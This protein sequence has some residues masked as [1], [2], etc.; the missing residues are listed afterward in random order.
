MKTKVINNKYIYYQSSPQCFPSGT[1]LLGWPNDANLLAGG[2]VQV[3]MS[4]VAAWLSTAT[5]GAPTGRFGHTSIWTGSEMIIWGGEAQVGFDPQNTGGRYNP[6]TDTWATLPTN[7]APSKR[8]EHTAVWTGSEMIIWGGRDGST[9]LNDGARYNP[10]T[11]TWT[12]LSTNGA[13]EERGEHT[14][15]WTGSEMIIWGGTKDQLKLKNNGARY[16]PISNSWTTISTSGAP[17][18]RH[19]HTAVWTGSEMIVWGGRGDNY[20]YL[21]TGGCYN[22]STNS[23]KETNPSNNYGCPTPQERTEHSAVWTGSVMIIWGG[24][25]SNGNPL[26]DGWIYD[27]TIT[28][29]PNSSSWWSLHDNSEV[30]SGRSNH[31]AVWTGSE[32]I[33]WGGEKLG[34][35]L[36]SGARYNPTNESWTATTTNGA[37]SPRYG[38]TV[39]WC[40]SELI[41]WSGCE[42]IP[43]S[44]I[45]CPNTGG[46]FTSGLYLY[47]QP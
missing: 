14:A 35:N 33:I 26:S 38:G 15:V 41:V 10:S 22:P 27:P 23:W 46:R 28:N 4:N 1:I 9:Y 34:S 29:S 7:G 42:N 47:H 11:D 8:E 36:N 16:N 25:S 30:P 21:G 31:A 2:F 39:L 17:S 6:S 37:P 32:M 20:S 13:P 3:G 40:G 24:V 18:K 43:G 12:T 19:D 45:T 44:A 5:N